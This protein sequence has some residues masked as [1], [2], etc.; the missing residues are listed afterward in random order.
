MSRK[1]GAK[2][3]LDEPRNDGTQDVISRIP[4]G[5]EIELDLSQIEY[6][7]CW[8]GPTFDPRA[9]I[10]SSDGQASSRCKA[11]VSGVRQI[12]ADVVFDVNIIGTICLRQQDD[13]GDPTTIEFWYSERPKQLCWMPRRRASQVEIEPAL[14][15]W[16]VA[17]IAEIE[18]SGFKVWTAEY[19]KHRSFWFR[20]AASIERLYLGPEVRLQLDGP[21]HHIGPL[22]N[23]CLEYLPC[24]FSAAIEQFQKQKTLQLAGE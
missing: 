11:T 2:R 10:K 21:L 18:L 19:Q 24:S 22:I 9:R 5:L 8:Y 17:E 14:S 7:L 15:P 6:D 1:R 23:I 13:T 12:G 20:N 3:K 4:I 16:M